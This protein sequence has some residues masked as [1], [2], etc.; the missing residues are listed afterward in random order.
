MIRNT[1]AG[2]SSRDDEEYVERIEEEVDRAHDEPQAEGD[3]DE[4]AER[5]ELVSR[6]QASRGQ[7]GPHSE[8]SLEYAHTL[9]EISDARKVWIRVLRTR[10]F[11]PTILGGGS[12]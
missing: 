7:E 1:A 6:V 4:K 5:L 11:G 2:N 9:L 10:R 3:E 8:I 12:E